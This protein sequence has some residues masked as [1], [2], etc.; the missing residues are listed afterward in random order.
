ML[1]CNITKDEGQKPNELKYRLRR[2]LLEAKATVP[3][4][5]MKQENDL[6]RSEDA[7]KL[8]LDEIN[9]ELEKLWNDHSQVILDATYEHMVFLIQ[10][11]EIDRFKKYFEM[12]QFPPSIP[13][14]DKSDSRYTSAFEYAHNANAAKIFIYMMDMID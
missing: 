3:A 7:T 2:K 5:W 12:H 9:D 1:E 4:A 11:H 8:L 13:L 10:N 14:Y 6:K